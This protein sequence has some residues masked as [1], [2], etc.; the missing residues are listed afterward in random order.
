MRWCRSS[1]VAAALLLGT[2]SLGAKQAAP[3][4]TQV[5]LHIL[6]QD[7]RIAELLRSLQRGAEHG[8]IVIRNVQLVDAVAETVTPGQSLIVRN[9]VIDW[10]GNAAKEPQVSGAAVID[11]G[12]RYLAPGLVDMHVH[13]S[14]AGGWLLDLANGVTAVR[15]MGGFPWLLRFRES[16]S[17]RRILAPVVYLAGPIINGEPLGGYAVMPRNVLDARRI[18]RQQAAC[19]YDFIKV[20]NILSLPMLEAIADEASKLGMDLVGH[21]PHDISVRNAVDRSA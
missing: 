2:S 17:A 10:M 11:G 15:D 1:T 14:S 12:G 7:I 3:T 4:P 19:G 16:V 18:V 13:S 5:A 20:H 8:L 9:D 21:V 6:Q